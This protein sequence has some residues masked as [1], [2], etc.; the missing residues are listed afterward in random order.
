ML[1]S[2]G[3][4]AGTS[5][6]LAVAGAATFYLVRDGKVSATLYLLAWLTVLTAYYVK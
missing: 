1:I 4:I 5:C 6:I 3:L 2:S